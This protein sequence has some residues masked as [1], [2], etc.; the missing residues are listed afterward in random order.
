MN[1]IANGNHEISLIPG[2]D[3]A[4]FVGGNF[5]GGNLTLSIA[6]DDLSGILP[7]PGYESISTNTSFVLTAPSHRLRLSVTGATAPEIFVGCVLFP[8]GS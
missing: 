3:Y 2:R 6:N 7:V 8:S 4:V 5:A 1:L